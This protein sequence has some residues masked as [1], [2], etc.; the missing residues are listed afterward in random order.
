MVQAMSGVPSIVAGLFIFAAVILTDVVGFS[1]IAGGLAYAILM[2]PT[3]ARTAEEVLRLVPKEVRDAAVAL[4]SS[5]A[6]VTMRIVLP[7]A[8]TGLITAVVLGVAR[9]IGETAPLLLTT[10]NANNTNLNPFSDPVSTIPVYIFQ[11]LG[12][13]Y[14]TSIQRAWGAALVL[15]LAVAILFALTRYLSRNK[16]GKV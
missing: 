14:Q 8:K 1:A 12:S 4:G 5:R 10:S 2:L 9:I 6:R 13:G 3:V 7:T 16:K 11:Y 15:L